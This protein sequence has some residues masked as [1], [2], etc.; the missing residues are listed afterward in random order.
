MVTKWPPQLQV[1][2]PHMNELSR[3]ERNK[4][5]EFLSAGEEK[6]PK[7]KIIIIITAIN[8]GMGLN[9]CQLFSIIYIN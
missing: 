7:K 1:F 2:L 5:K 8:A 6:N 9:L 4:W 3:K